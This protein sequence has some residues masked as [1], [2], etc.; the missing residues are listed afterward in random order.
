MVAIGY[1]R[2]NVIVKGI[3]GFRMTYPVALLIIIS[4]Y[5]YST[6]ICIP[7]FLGWGG[8]ALGKTKIKFRKKCHLSTIF[9]VFSRGIA[10]YM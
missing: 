6:L 3:S 5:A 1:D 10:S 8:Y 7:P 9:I 4:I 2:Y